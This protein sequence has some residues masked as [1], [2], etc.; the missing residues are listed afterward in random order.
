MDVSFWFI[1][2]GIIYGRKMSDVYDI[3]VSKMN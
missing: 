1:R 2:G 3:V